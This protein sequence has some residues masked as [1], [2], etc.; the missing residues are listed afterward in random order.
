MPYFKGSRPGGGIRRSSCSNATNHLPDGRIMRYMHA[1]GFRW[2]RTTGPN[3]WF[4]SEAASA[5]AR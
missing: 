2:R 4:Y 1:N 5:P 3:D